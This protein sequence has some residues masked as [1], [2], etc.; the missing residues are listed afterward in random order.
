MKATKKSIGLTDDGQELWMFRL[1]NNNSMAIELI[2]IGARLHA[3]YVPD[4]RGHLDDILQGFSE[5]TQYLDSD[6]YYGAVCGPF[7]N[8]IENGLVTI[9]GK[10]YRLPQNE[11]KTCLHSGPNGFHHRIW[12]HELREDEVIFS[13]A[14]ETE[15]DGFPGSF[16]C[17]VRYH[18]TGDNCLKLRYELQAKE[19]CLFSPTNHAYF[20]LSSASS[21]DLSG[22]TLQ[23]NAKFMTPTNELNLV[24]GEVIS[25]KNSAWDFLEPRDLYAALKTYKE[26]L[27]KSRGYDHNFILTKD[28]PRSM[29]LAAVLCHE[30]SGRELR[31]FSTQPGLQVYTANYP[32]TEK[33]KEGLL[34]PPQSSVCLETQGIPNSP[35][36]S[37][38]P[39]AIVPAGSHYYEE[40]RY[41][42]RLRA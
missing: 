12:A 13:C 41:E 34:Y 6:N 35:A 42:F 2:N 30:G 4:R 3:I 31:I 21:P 36:H 22:H 24:T 16:L 37:H 1:E 17:S 33:G 15:E 40:T 32:P 8:R 38:L 26:T 28:E 25:V 9:D 19:T 11:G 5:P 18:L 20:N 27:S 29:S 10:R 23:V 14:Y 7:A 39:S